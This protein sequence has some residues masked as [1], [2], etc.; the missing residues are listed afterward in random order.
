[1]AY[2]PE[3]DKLLDWI[4]SSGLARALKTLM[5]TPIWLLSKEV[6]VLEAVEKQYLKACVFAVY[7]VRNL[8]ETLLFFC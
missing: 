4:V 6:G 7:L 3:A 5:I 1:M 2:R 8:L